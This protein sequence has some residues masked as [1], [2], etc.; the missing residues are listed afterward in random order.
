M[1]KVVKIKVPKVKVIDKESKFLTKQLLLS[2]ILSK[3][4][5]ILNFKV[6]NQETNYSKIPNYKPM[7]Y[8]KNENPKSVKKELTDAQLK[9]LKRQEMKEQDDL[10]RLKDK[11]ER[12]VIER[13]RIERKQEDPNKTKMMMLSKKD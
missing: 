3:M 1:R 10:R 4:R 7:F 6:L 8:F 11:K 2:I 5:K 9:A 13:G 12:N